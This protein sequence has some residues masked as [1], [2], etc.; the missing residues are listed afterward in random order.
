MVQS[1]QEWPWCSLA[2][3]APAE[4]PHWLLPMSAVAGGRAGGGLDIARESSRE[5]QKELEAMQTSVKRGRPYGDDRWQ[6]QTAKRLALEST[7]RPRG[8]QR[9]QANQ[10]LPTPHPFDFPFVE[11]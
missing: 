7:L 3:R 10:R 5:T 1:A 11:D 2:K 9:M 8:R 6:R 4:P